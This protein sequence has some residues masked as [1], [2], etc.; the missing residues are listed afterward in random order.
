MVA[1]STGKPDGVK[2]MKELKACGAAPGAISGMGRNAL[3]IACLKGHKDVVQYLMSSADGATLKN[4]QDASGWTP[5][6]CAVINAKVDV[7]QLIASKVN[8][9]ITD[10]LGRTARNTQMSPQPRYWIKFSAAAGPQRKSKN[11]E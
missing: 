3:H 4:T 1:S 8:R 9:T 7:L 2:I 5:Y 6:H 11:N 10:N